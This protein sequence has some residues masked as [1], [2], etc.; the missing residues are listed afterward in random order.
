MLSHEPGSPDFS[1]SVRKLACVGAFISVMPYPMKT[2]L[3]TQAQI[4]ATLVT[5][6]HEMS[7]VF[8]VNSSVHCKH[9]VSGSANHKLH[10]A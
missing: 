8:S 1:A 3:Q 7:I 6:S 5:R 9:T 10:A 2:N 4:L